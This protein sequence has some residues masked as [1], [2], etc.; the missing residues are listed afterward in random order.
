MT[1]YV[2]GKESTIRIRRCKAWHGRDMSFPRH[3][4]IKADFQQG[5]PGIGRHFDQPLQ[6]YQLIGFHFRELIQFLTHVN[7]YF[8]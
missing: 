4:V 8:Y 3:I 2:Y 1:F 6:I 5:L 7:P